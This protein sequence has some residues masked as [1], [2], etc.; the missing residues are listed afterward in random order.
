MGQ[1]CQKRIAFLPVIQFYAFRL[2][3][4]ETSLVDDD[5]GPDSE[6][7]AEGSHPFQVMARGPTE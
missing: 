7:I 4:I 1:F 2:I 5:S 6:M 3:R